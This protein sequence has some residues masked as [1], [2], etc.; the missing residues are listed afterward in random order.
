MSKTVASQKTVALPVHD[1]VWRDSAWR[2]RLR[3][4][5]LSWYRKHS[6]D[7]PW[8]DGSTP[9]RVWVSE[10]ML[11][12]T[13]VSTVIPYYDRFLKSFPTIAK[14][15]AADEQTLLSHWEGL[16]Y[17]RRARSMHAAAK[18]MV[19]E[20]QGEFPETYEEVLAL[21]G[22]GRYTAGAIL[23]ISRGQRLPILEGNTQR[24]FSR[25][26][27]LRSPATETPANKLLWK[28]AEE[29]LPRKDAGTFNQAAMELGALICTPRRPE[30]EAC[31]VASSC[32][33]RKLGLEEVVPGKVSR[34]KYEDRTEHAFV[35]AAPS[36]RAETNQK[37]LVRPLPEGRRWAGL[38]DFPR[39]SETASDTVEVAATLL[40]DELGVKIDPGLR[41]TTLKHAVTKY[42]I[43]LH[44][45]EACLSES[46]KRPGRPWKFVTLAEMA[47][48]PMSVTGRK[49][50]VLLGSDRQ[51]RLPL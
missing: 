18:L 9:Y 13:Q 51:T 36:K 27:A 19:R 26:I 34:V 1:D 41:L 3:R 8:R 10:I 39:T 11:Q 28:V 22:I 37:Y 20:H 23:S 30:C 24:V 4:R 43:S 2:S 17:Y 14:L 12:Q 7:L 15:A 35:L 5:L 21:P 50:A 25:W 40:S 32:Q 44:V 47:D 45:H 49:I 46:T 48:L 6:R 29:M 33:A 38:W 42:R 31:P 16:G